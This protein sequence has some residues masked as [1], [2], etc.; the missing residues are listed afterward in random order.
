MWVDLDHI[1]T[2][3]W[4]RPDLRSGSRSWTFRNCEN[5]T[6]LRLSPLSFWRGA[7]NWG[8]IVIVL[9]WEYSVSEPDFWIS[10]QESYY[11]SSNFVQCR[12][13]TKLK[14]PYFGTAWC[15]SHVVGHAASPT[16]TVYV[17]MSD[18]YPIQGQGHGAFELPTIAHKCTFIRLSPRPLSREAQNWRLLMIVWD[19]IYSLS[20]P[21]FRIS[22]QEN[23]H[24]SSNFPDCRYFTKLRWPYFGSAWRY[25]QM[26]GQWACWYYRY[27]ACWY[28]LDLIQ[29][30]GKVHGAFE[31]TKISEAVHYGGN[32][33]QPPCG[34]LWFYC[35]FYG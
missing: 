10:F 26:V 21:D 5:C 15:Y 1:Y 28:D 30:Q 16:R 11:A 20:E 33:R 18:L 25:S 4:P 29:G 7:Q 31:L 3:V 13:F 14:W 24:E 35:C 32:D 22:F 6:F 12:H 19:L 8:L 9:D 2:P 23:Y 17:D 34:A 27:C